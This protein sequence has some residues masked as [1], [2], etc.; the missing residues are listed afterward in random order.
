MVRLFK[1]RQKPSAWQACLL[2][3]A[4]VCLLSAGICISAEAANIYR[5]VDNNGHT[6]YNA[7][8]PPEFVGNGYTVLN[9]RG[10]VIEVVPRALTAAEIAARANNREAQEQTEAELR[11]QM[12]ADNLLLRLFRSPEEVERKRDER[13]RQIDAQLIALTATM[14]KTEAEIKRLNDIADNARANGREPLAENL[15]NIDKQNT[16]LNRLR[17]QELRLQENK[18]VAR[19]EASEDIRRL[20]VLLNLPEEPATE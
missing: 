3:P 5:Y 2:K 11:K 7:I 16:E 14:T 10:M 15:A 19:A 18:E 1:Y 8:M 13:I 20:R 6:V 4:L 17:L 9:E 12:E